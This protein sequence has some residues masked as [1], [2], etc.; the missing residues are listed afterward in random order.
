I[1]ESDTGY[2]LEI[3]LPGFSKEEVTVELQDGYLTVSAAKG[4]DKNEA[5]SE[6]EAKKGNYIR[7]ERYSGACQRSFYV[8]EDVTQQDIKAN[9]KHGILTLNIPK[10]DAKA[11]QTKNYITIEG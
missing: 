8:G 11:V 10:K 6:E 3:D 4:L 7:R 9:F 2:E 5:E 1:K